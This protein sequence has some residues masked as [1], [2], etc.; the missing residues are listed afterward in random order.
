MPSLAWFRFEANV[1]ILYFIIPIH[2]TEILNHTA[3]SRIMKKIFISLALLAFMAV[4]QPHGECSNTIT[5]TQCAPARFNAL[6]NILTI[7]TVLVDQSRYEATFEPI[8]GHNGSVLLRLI[9]LKSVDTDCTAALYDGFSQEIFVPQ[10]SLGQSRYALTL[11]LNGNCRYGDQLICL[12]L[13]DIALSDEAT[14]I[15]DHGLPAP[16]IP[17]SSNHPPVLS[18]LKMIRDGCLNTGFYVEHQYNDS[19]GVTDVKRHYVTTDTGQLFVLESDGSGL[20]RVLVSFKTTGSHWLQFQA[21]DSKGA[22]GNELAGSV[23]IKDCAVTSPGGS[24]SLPL[25][26]PSG[27]GEEA[28]GGDSLACGGGSIYETELCQLI[29]Q[30]RTAHGLTTLSF[31]SVLYGLAFDHSQAMSESGVLSHDGFYERC[32]A[33]G[34]TGCVENVGWNY[35]TAQAQFE[36]WK[37]SPGHDSNMLNTSIKYLGIAKSGPYV[38]FLATW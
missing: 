21:T 4:P 23:Y 26:P 16:P 31:N 2:S 34:A 1:P 30:Y 5:V 13:L 11:G 35:L 32:A 20:F 10:L 37:N 6:T 25:P 22:I 9:A 28:P 3:R 8:F 38:T 15:T 18:D 27:S 7:P 14:G 29:N 24:G 33:C 36:G 19:N 12:E 17:P